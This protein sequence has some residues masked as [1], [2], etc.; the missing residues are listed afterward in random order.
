M[1]HTLSEYNED[2]FLLEWLVGQLRAHQPAA[3]A[4]AEDALL[5]DAAVWSHAPVDVHRDVVEGLRQWA[6]AAG[7]E[8]MMASLGDLAG[9]GGSDAPL[10]VVACLLWTLPLYCDVRR[11]KS[12]ES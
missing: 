11:W 7:S 4:D 12:G 5:L 10:T 1:R 8:G 6:A 3:A 2:V 9:L